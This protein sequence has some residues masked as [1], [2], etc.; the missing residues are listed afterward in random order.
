M[1]DHSP[2]VLYHTSTR[3]WTPIGTKGICSEVLAVNAGSQEFPIRI[4]FV[5]CGELDKTRTREVKIGRSWDD[6]R[7][8]LRTTPFQT[9]NIARLPNSAKLTF[10][11]FHIWTTRIALSPK[12]LIQLFVSYCCLVSFIYLVSALPLNFGVPSSQA[13]LPSSSSAAPCRPDERVI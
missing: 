4:S 1:K 11:S 2:R 9:L 12:L 8:I 5:L 10:S 7:K 3:R 13:F 6:Y